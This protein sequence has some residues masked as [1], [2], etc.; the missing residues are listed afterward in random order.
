MSIIRIIH[1]VCIQTFKFIESIVITLLQNL[2][3]FAS[4]VIFRY[5]IIYLL[6]RTAIE[7]TSST[8]GCAVASK[9]N[10]MDIAERIETS[11]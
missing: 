7:C 4:F 5:T 6:F 1:N 2:S 8:N 9:T 10:V 3:C 11:S